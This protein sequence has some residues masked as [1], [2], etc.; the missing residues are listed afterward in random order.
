MKVYSLLL[1]FHS[2]FRWLVLSGLAYAL[3]RG[4]RGWS[5]RRV[6]SS[7]DDKVRH[8]TA[9]LAHV[10]LVIGYG[11]YFNSPLV[12]WFRGHYREAMGQLQVV[13]FGLIHILL[14]TLAIVLVTIGS[15][16][17]K[18]KTTD[19]RKFRTMTLWYLAA[20]VIILLAVPWPFSPFA[21]RPFFRTF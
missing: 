20:L 2:L 3:W 11:L 6:F 10:Q 18:R 14:M 8:T 4:V 5:G 7:T 17:A 12:Q 9:T 15:A 16:A 21:R 13:F 19:V 1:F